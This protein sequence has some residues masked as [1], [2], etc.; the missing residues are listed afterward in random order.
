MSR[1][2]KLGM[3]TIAL[4]L[5]SNREYGRE[6]LKGIARFAYERKDW[7]LKLI[8]QLGIDRRLQ[9]SECS[10]V[11]ARVTDDEA[12][13]RL[14]SL[15]LP[16]ID[17][18]R[19]G[20][21]SSAIMVGCDNGAIASMAAKHFL[22]RGFRKFAFCGYRGTRYS[23]ERFA[24]F[25]KTLA[26]A[27]FECGEYPAVEKPADIISY[28]DQTMRPKNMRRFAAWVSN[29]PQ[30]TAVFCAN[31]IRAYHVLR[32]CLDI[33]RDVPS[34]IA[35]MGVD[36][37]SVLCSCAT[38][39]L[40]SID[41]NAFNV[42]YAAARLLDTAIE[43]PDVTQKEHP[44]FLVKPMGVV[45]RKSTATYPVNLPWLTKAL[46]Y[47]DDNMNKPITAG[48]LVKLAN[49]SQTALQKV[50]RKVFG[51]SV[52][53][54]ILGVKMREARRLAETGNLFVKEIAAMTGFDDPK[55]F[56]RTYRAYFGQ[57][58]S[59]TVMSRHAVL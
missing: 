6:L 58:P 1:K 19:Q 13:R 18:F 2:R 9:L 33:G 32:V 23:D 24:A 37:D 29:L 36:N 14:L 38:V 42:G 39:S 12:M 11:I 31:D 45:E 7:Q 49:V 54:Y 35:I 34:D 22:R 53:R 30:N 21:P 25:M 15:K 16:V 5:E 17:M 41:P 47:I 4:I 40:T 57:T 51:V 3:K 50:F 27:G 56:C 55:Y 59:H 44:A 28:G 20:K 48:D 8:P 46:A 43:H 26:E 52:G 10:G